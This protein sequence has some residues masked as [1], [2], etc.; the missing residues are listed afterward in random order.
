MAGAD[1]TS[2]S[3][4]LKEHY[5]KNMAKVLWDDPQL[6]PCLGIM[7]KRSGKYDAGGRSFVAP[8]QY[9]DG[10]SISADFPT[11]QAKAQGTSTGASN[12][13]TRWTVNAVSVNAVGL[14]DR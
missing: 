2:V 7:E 4:A 1:Q 11:A 8:I 14:W 3:A 13:Y 9:G 10:S 5:A 12:L 6:T